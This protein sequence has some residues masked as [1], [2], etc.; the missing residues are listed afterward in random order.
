MFAV[1]DDCLGANWKAVVGK[2]VRD[3]RMILDFPRFHQILSLNS[4]KKGTKI[5][6]R[7]SQGACVNYGIYNII[8]AE[9]KTILYNI[10]KE[11]YENI[12]FFNLHLEFL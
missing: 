10:T 8:T 3:A 9:M 5:A 12:F 2:F 11:L 4:S 1:H 6:I 7:P